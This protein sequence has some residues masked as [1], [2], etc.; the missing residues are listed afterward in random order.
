MPINL[1]ELTPSDFEK[2]VQVL[3]TRSGY[4]AEISP[5]PVGSDIEGTNGSGERLFVDVKHFKRPLPEALIRRFS[6]DFQRYR[7]QFPDAKGLIVVSNDLSPRATKV[8]RDYPELA[9]WTGEVL[10]RM[11]AEHP[12]VENAVQLAIDRHAP[13]EALLSI[14]LP[15][16]PL[17]KVFEHR[18]NAIRP[19]PDDWRIFEKW[20]F[21][22]LTDIFRP[23]LGPPAWQKRTNDRLDIMDAI[24]PIRAKTHPWTQVR[25]D[26]LTRFVIAEFKNHSGA[27]GQEE[28]ESIA[29][30][31]LPKAMRQFGILV[32]RCEPSKSA[33]DQRRKAWLTDNKMIVMLSSQELIE[34]LQMREGGEEPFD[35][36]DAQIEDFLMPLSF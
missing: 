4:R 16:E 36:I 28:V 8:V 5:S 25:A 15:P 21:E 9:I 11:L 23:D 13:L 30:Y 6:G 1:N 18:L 31:F 27:I 19:G 34:M 20:C 17:S 2:L 32:S 14:R 3:L 24:F 7:L 12:D 33:L 26:F 29:Q 35:V 10:T 22:I